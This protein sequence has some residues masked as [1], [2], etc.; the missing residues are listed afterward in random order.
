MAIHTHSIHVENQKQYDELMIYLGKLGYRWNGSLK[1]PSE[2]NDHFCQRS[3]YILCLKENK[4]MTH[5]NISGCKKSYPDIPITSFREF[6][7]PI[8]SEYQREFKR[9]FRVNRVPNPLT[10]EQEKISRKNNWLI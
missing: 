4:R 8:K 5:Y 2:D 6:I 10:I 1:N 9:M 7:S 3:D